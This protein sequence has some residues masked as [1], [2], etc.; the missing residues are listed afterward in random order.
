MLA[1]HMLTPVSLANDTATHLEGIRVCLKLQIHVLV[2]VMWCVSQPAGHSIT[3]D[4]AHT[5]KYTHCK[6]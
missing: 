4:I 6:V 1:L 2:V 3:S 5:Y